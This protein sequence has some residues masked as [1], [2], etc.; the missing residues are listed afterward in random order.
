MVKNNID[1]V[2]CPDNMFELNES[3]SNPKQSFP[4]VDILVEKENNPYLLG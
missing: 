1:A 4:S 3:N 2:Q